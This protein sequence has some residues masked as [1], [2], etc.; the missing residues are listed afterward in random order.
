MERLYTP[1]RMKYVTSTQKKIDGCVFCAKLEDDESDRENL[2]LFRGTTT[3][4]VMNLYPYNTGHLMILPYN[5]VANLSDVS[6]EARLEMMNN[7]AYFVE[8]LTKM[9]RPDGFNIGINLGRVA[10]AGIAAH[11]HQHIVPRWGGDSNFMAVV[12]ETRIL[13]EELWDT[14]DRIIEQVQ[15]SPPNFA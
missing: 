3:F 4:T 15:Q 12:G 5:H 2:I 11:L 6:P 8:L 9:M 13:P 7:T 14:Y 10:G 1:W